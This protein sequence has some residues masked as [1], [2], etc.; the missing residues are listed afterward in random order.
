MTLANVTSINCRDAIAR[1]FNSP[2]DFVVRNTTVEYNDGST[3]KASLDSERNK[4]PA[5]ATCYRVPRVMRLTLLSHYGQGE[6][7]GN[8]RHGKGRFI[9]SDSCTYEGNWR[10]DAL[11]GRGKVQKPDGQSYDG[12]WQSGMAHGCVFIHYQ[13]WCV[14]CT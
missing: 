11:E 13:Q 3:Y 7:L 4:S 5:F 9:L 1:G 12:E 10:Y 2:D 14:R 6:V 8:L